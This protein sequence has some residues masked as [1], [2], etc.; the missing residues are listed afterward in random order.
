MDHSV[1]PI[2]NSEGIYVA[3]RMRPLNDRE[4]S[5]GEEV[6]F[7][8][9]SNNSISQVKDNHL[10]ENQTYS[11]DKVFDGSATTAEVYTHVGKDA[12]RNVAAGINGTIFACK[13]YTPAS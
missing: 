10:V 9:T 13:V 5:N 1:N 4:K 3:I 7:G 12:V 11:Y 2:Q 6:V 8:C